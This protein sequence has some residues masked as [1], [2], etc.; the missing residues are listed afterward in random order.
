MDKALEY[1]Q[2]DLAMRPENI[3]A[4]ELVAW[5][6]NL[7]GD[8]ANAKIHADKMLA[9][10]TQ[11]ATTLYKAGVIYANAGAMQQSN[12]YMRNAM[13]INPYIDQ[14]LIAMAKPQVALNQK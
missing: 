10:K 3:D 5:I 8:Y 1:A 13:T 6:Y 12:D 2:I 9:T 11:N 14:R 4:N 7:K